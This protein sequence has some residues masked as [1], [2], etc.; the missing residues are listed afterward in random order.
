MNETRPESSFENRSP[1]ASTRYRE[2][3]EIANR[4]PVV[5]ERDYD[6]TEAENT[7]DSLTAREAKVFGITP[8]LLNA[9]LY[10]HVR[11]EDMIGVT[12]IEFDS[13]RDEERAAYPEWFKGEC[14]YS[15]EDAISFM[16]LV[17]RLPVTQ[18]IAWVCRAKIQQVRS[19]LIDDAVEPADWAFGTV[20]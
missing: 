2:L 17:C 14:M 6:L 9:L 3:V 11:Y 19:G 15:M 8:S 13:F 1:R 18:A 4:E 5:V 16:A 10:A 12:D 20:E 7:W